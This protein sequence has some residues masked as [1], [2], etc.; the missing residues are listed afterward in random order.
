MTAR[1]RLAVVAAT[2]VAA[3]GVLTWWTSQEPQSATTESQDAVVERVVD[4]DT[5]LL[6]D[7]ERVR[8]L[9]ID[10]PEAARDGRPAECGADE[11]TAAARRLVEGRPVR[12]RSDPGQADR[13]DFDRLLRYVE[14][15]DGT[16]LGLN[17]VTE[18]HARVF[19]P[20]GDVARQSSLERAE[21]QARDRGV[22]TWTCSP[23]GA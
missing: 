23:P 13:D 14:T 4:G 16:D 1:A 9:G 7:G 3:T 6:A 11:A 5:L 21:A 19:A 15:P 12:L 2:A 22:G 18:G 8:V 17:L 20:R 10:A